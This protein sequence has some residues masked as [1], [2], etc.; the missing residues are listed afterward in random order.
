MSF[1]YIRSQFCS[2]IYR[3]FDPMKMIAKKVLV[4]IA[5]LGK[6][7]IEIRLKASLDIDFHAIQHGL[8]H[9]ITFQ[10]C[11]EGF[12][13]A[14]YY[15]GYSELNSSLWYFVICQLGSTK[16]QSISNR[17]FVTVHGLNILMP[18]ELSGW[19]WDDPVS[20]ACMPLL[21]EVSRTL[22][23][24]GRASNASLSCDYQSIFT[25]S[26]ISAVADARV[27][28]SA[29]LARPRQKPERSNNYI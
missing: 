16:V 13:D 26:C 7:L 18:L 22:G 15:L 2:F 20:I 24:W 6:G 21:P 3:Y 1:W 14:K 17:D 8:C 9:F 11:N 5:I 12:M 19:R 10:N 25:T 27:A 23:Y 4:W 28:A 29:L